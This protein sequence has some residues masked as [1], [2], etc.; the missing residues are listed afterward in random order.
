MQRPVAGQQGRMLPRA[1][2][3]GRRPATRDN[4][5]RRGGIGK[6][7][8]IRRDVV[9]APLAQQQAL[10]LESRAVHRPLVARECAQIALAL[11]AR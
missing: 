11:G 1:E 8:A 7:V 5:A 6:Q 2:R 3:L 9:G 10:G 4:E